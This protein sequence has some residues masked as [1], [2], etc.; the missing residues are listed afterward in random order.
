MSLLCGFLAAVPDIEL[1][2]E[3]SIE[4]LVK[5]PEVGTAPSRYAQPYALS[6]SLGRYM[7]SM[8]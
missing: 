6:Q 4:L 5:V 7:I 2:I 1:S 3:L 8:C